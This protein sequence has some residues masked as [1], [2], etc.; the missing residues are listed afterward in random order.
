MVLSSKPASGMYPPGRPMPAPESPS[1]E[2]A[3]SSSA[4]GQAMVLCV[5]GTGSDVGKSWLATGI[6]RVFQ[7][8]GVDVVPYKAQNMSN[9][10]GVTPE[11]GEMGRAQIVQAEACGLTPH[12]DMNPLLLKPNTDTGAQVVLLGRAV[13][14]VEARSYFSGGMERRRRPVLAALDRLRTRYELVVVEGAGSCAEVNLRDRDL[15]NFP[16]AHHGDAPVVLVADINKGGVFA[17]VVGTLEVLLPDDRARVAGVIINRFRGDVGLFADGVRWLEE[18]TGVPVL[19]VVPWLSAAR[20][21]SEDGMQAD[22]QLD[23]PAPTAAQRSERAHVAVLRL[24]HIA[25]F[26]DVEVLTRYGVQVHYLARPRD[27]AAYDLVILPGT[28]NTRGD[29]DWLRGRRWVERIDAY[30]RGDGR[31][32]GLCGGYQMMG[33]WIEDPHGV[34]GPSGG[35]EGLGLLPARTVLAEHKRTV[36]TSARLLLPGVAEADTA[37]VHGYEI[38]AGRTEVDPLRSA[39]PFL[40]LRGAG[41][42]RTDGAWSADTRCGGTYLH[43]LFDEPEA[44]HALLSWCRPDLPPVGEQTEST[45]DWRQRQYDLLADHLEEHLD[46]DLLFELAGLEAAGGA[47]GRQG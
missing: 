29:L 15:V 21:D 31:L 30:L 35:S 12:V 23:R 28:K 46:T 1:V 27:L 47:P 38:H 11:G 37:V 36:R 34:E 14:T 20:I 42:A 41:S 6:A 18:R 9:N 19:G 8:A 16:V 7:R 44:A 40:A 3:R 13:G 25:N 26:T 10:A 4:P 39:G 32:L 33:E 24:P 45:Y 17:Q 43:G 22:V 2:A 5:F